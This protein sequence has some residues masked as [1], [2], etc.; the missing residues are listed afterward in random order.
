MNRKTQTQKP[1]GKSQKAK[2]K[3]VL[4][5]NS[6]VIKIGS[7]VCASIQKNLTLEKIDESNL[8]NYNLRLRE[9]EE[10]FKD[11][12]DCMKAV[13][14]GQWLKDNLKDNIEKSNEVLIN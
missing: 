8:I 12:I 4:G 7:C 1:N 14:I 5:F 9:T 11:R 10:S 6:F 13:L 2:A 3:K